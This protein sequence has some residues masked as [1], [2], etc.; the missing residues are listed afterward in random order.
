MKLFKPKSIVSTLFSLIYSSIL[1]LIICTSC[2]DAKNVSDKNISQ[3]AAKVAPLFKSEI[4][5]DSPD[6]VLPYRYFDPSDQGNGSQKYPLILCL[7]GEDERGTDNEAQLV[8][9]ECATIW[10]EP[11]HF[12][13]NPAFVLAP[14]LPQ[15]TDWT[16]EPYYNNVLNLLDE[17]VSEHP[18]IDPDRIYIVGFSM[19]GTGVW[20]MI[21]KNPDLFAAAMP[22][23][24]NA[25]AF[26][27]NYEAFE[28]LK[29][30]P[31]LVAH[32]IDDPISPVSGTNNAIAALRAVGNQ[33][34]MT[35]IWGMGSVVPPHD[36]WY[37]LP[38]TIMR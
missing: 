30:L 6:N 10:I 8:T 36:A 11:D 38:F 26:L 27:G 34:V 16:M 32:S 33:S 13:K 25:D 7:H 28:A 18:D 21:L 17:F 29:N 5:Q 20:N 35:N 31:V 9:T 12:A 14:Q 2:S 15:N 3:E 22:I 23:T 1:L 24:G 4:F 19:G 37:P